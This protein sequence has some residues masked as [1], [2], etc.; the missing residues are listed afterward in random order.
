[1]KIV[2]YLCGFNYKT[3]RKNTGALCNTGVAFAVAHIF[4]KR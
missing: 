2:G 4:D 1:M 3:E